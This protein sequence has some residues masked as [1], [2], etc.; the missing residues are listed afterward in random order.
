MD[1]LNSVRLL[2]LSDIHEAEENVRKIIATCAN[3]AIDYVILSGDF[4]NLPN[5]D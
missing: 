1:N 3:K 5:E 4:L 2:L